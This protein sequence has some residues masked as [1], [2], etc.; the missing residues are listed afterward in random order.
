MK[1]V[2]D[3]PVPKAKISR[4]AVGI[5]GLVIS[6]SIAITVPSLFRERGAEAKQV[7]QIHSL[8]LT[9]YSFSADHGQFPKQLP[10]LIEEGY[11]DVEQLLHRQD[12]FGAKQPGPP[13][14]YRSG[15]SENSPPGEPLIAAPVPVGHKRLV[16]FTDGHVTMIRETEFQEKY[17]ALFD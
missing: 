1:T 12:D 16:G 8:I 11:L 5:F 4:R 3:H 17:A 10:D 7:K 6:A 14:L 13:L 2:A 15:L 9:C